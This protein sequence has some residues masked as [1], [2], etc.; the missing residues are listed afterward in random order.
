[1]S[2]IKK[3]VIA[4]FKW[5][6]TKAPRI[7]YIPFVIPLAYFLIFNTLFLKH[8]VDNIPII[9]YDESQ[10]HI[11]REIAHCFED[12]E[13]FKVIGYANSQE[14]MQEYLRQRKADA[15]IYIPIDL[16]KRINTH[17]SSPVLFEA[18]GTNMLVASTAITN[19]QNIISDISQNIGVNLLLE[20]NYMPEQANNMVTPV[21]KEFRILYNPYLSYT[22]YFVYALLMIS[23]HMALFFCAS[24]SMLMEYNLGKYKEYSAKQVMLGKL[25]PF[26][27]LGIV[28]YIILAAIAILVHGTPFSGSLL[29][30]LAMGIVFVFAVT[31]LGA[32]LISFFRV[33]FYFYQLGLIIVVPIFLSSG[34]TFPVTYM[35]FINKIFS[36]LMPLS[37]MA[38]AM[39]SMILSGHSPHFITNVSSLLIYGMIALFLAIRRL[40][41]VRLQRQY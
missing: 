26:W 38:P 1:M 36:A 19:A 40:K 25:I 24:G 3:I 39:R 37:Y 22:N 7:A 21:Q 20:K 10:S 9:I 8:S 34:A 31:S 2:V 4:E 17:L 16:M 35:P 6:L 27:L 41:K 5:M 12:S 11:S 15:A 13:Y 33:M 28:Y 23:F 14:D 30:L 32:F 29:E 18:D